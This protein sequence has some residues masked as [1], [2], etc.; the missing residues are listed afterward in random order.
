MSW[1]FLVDTCGQR[2]YQHGIRP[3]MTIPRVERY[4]H[5]RS[6]AFLPRIRLRLNKPDLATKR[7]PSGGWHLWFTLKFA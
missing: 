3:L 4:D 1:S 7:R 2:N 5:Y 6:P